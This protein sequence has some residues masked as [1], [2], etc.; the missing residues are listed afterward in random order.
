MEDIR[1]YHDGKGV[2]SHSQNG[3]PDGHAAAMSDAIYKSIPITNIHEVFRKRF[4]DQAFIGFFSL[5][6]KFEM[7]VF[8]VYLFDEVSGKIELIK[9]SKAVFKSP[10]KA[11]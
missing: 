9:L 4:L 6:S 1:I 2:W 5:P 7:E 10:P 3:W 8:D 11:N